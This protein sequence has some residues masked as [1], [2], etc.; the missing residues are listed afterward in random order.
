[1][2][3]TN[4]AVKRPIATTMVFLIVIAALPAVYTTIKNEEELD[5]GNPKE[6]S[7]LKEH[8]K[9]I[10]FL[11]FLF[12]GVTTALSVSYVVLPHDT[13]SSVFSLQEKAIVNVNNYVQGDVTKLDIF[14][15]IFTNNL[16]VLFFC[17]LFS[18]LYGTGAIFIL[19]WNASVIATAIGA[20]VK[21]ELAKTATLMGLSSLSSYFGAATFGFFR[22]MSHG[23]LEIIAYFIIGL[24]GWL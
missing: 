5:V 4:V 13:V 9:V 22:Y 7:I 23:I 11:V 3:I 12:L 10:T 20:L 18:L 8:T 19:T 6:S 17:L 24:A 1:M 14:V 16:K 21:G 2:N 15:R